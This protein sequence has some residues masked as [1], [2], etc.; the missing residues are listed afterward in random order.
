MFTG[1]MTQRFYVLSLHYVVFENCPYLSIETYK[2][3]YLSIKLKLLITN[4]PLIYVQIFFLTFF[5]RI[6]I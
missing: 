2:N 3:I 5:P 6:E 4:L 1:I